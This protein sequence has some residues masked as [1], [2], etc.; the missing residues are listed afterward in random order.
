[1]IGEGTWKADENPSL[2]KESPRRVSI[3]MIWAL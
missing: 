2:C 3:T 1:V